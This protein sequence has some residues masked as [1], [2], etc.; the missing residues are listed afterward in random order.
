MSIE[1]E[2][3]NKMPYIKRTRRGCLM[4]AGKTENIGE[5]NYMITSLIIKYIKDHGLNYTNI[6]AIMGCLNCVG[7]EFYR[8]VVVSYEDKKKKQNGDVY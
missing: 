1:N 2:R 8:R 6:N 5:L 7:Q 3:K 4:P